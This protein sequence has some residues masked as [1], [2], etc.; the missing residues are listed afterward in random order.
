[1][2]EWFSSNN[3]MIGSSLKSVIECGFLPAIFGEM[4]NKISLTVNESNAGQRKVKVG[5][6]LSGGLL[7]E[8]PDR[9]IKWG[10]T[11]ASQIRK[12]SMRFVY[13]LVWD[14]CF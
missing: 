13:R 12:K 11:H 2:G 4:L 9:H 10:W 6:L 7:R 3:A 14:K 5:R 8:C 1:M